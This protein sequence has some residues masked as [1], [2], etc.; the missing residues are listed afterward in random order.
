Q[1][2]RGPHP[3]GPRAGGRRVG[4]AHHAATV[5]AV[6]MAGDR[7]GHVGDPFCVSQACGPVACR[8]YIPGPRSR[9]AAT[10]SPVRLA[11]AAARHPKVPTWW[12]V[13]AGVIPH[14]MVLPGRLGAVSEDQADL[15]RPPLC[16]H[17]VFA[18]Q[19][20]PLVAGGLLLIWIETMSDL[21]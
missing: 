4:R 19:A 9:P 15:P 6:L 10:I 20:A 8:T 3:P 16:L 14:P 1:P 21:G 2:G 13:A 11:A 5:F 12:N 7:F 17:D 18:A